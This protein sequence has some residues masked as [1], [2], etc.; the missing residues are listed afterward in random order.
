MG[1]HGAEIVHGGISLMKNLG[2]SEAGSTP[3]THER[4]SHTFCLAMTP[5]GRGGNANYF[6]L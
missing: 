3:G 4:F 2:V 1:L 6:Q 5:A